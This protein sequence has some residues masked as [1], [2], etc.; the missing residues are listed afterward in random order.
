MCVLLVWDF[1]VVDV[2]GVIIVN[3]KNVGV[4]FINC[5]G[6]ENV[7]CGYGWVFSGN[8]G[9]DVICDIVI[10]VYESILVIVGD[11]VSVEY[12]LVICCGV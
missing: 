10:C 12:G 1:I 6:E 7:I 8:V 2:C 5:V 4:F 3:N 11:V 9:L